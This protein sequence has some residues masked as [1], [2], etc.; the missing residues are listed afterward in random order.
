MSDHAVE[1]SPKSKSKVHHNNSALLE[2]LIQKFLS[3][4]L[5]HGETNGIT[6]TIDRICTLVQDF[7]PS[8]LDKGYKYVKTI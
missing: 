5:P 6:T 4:E 8:S 1:P 7:I 3:R 2:P